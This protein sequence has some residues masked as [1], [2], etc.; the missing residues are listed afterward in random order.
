VAS[1]TGAIPDVVIHGE[2]GFLAEPQDVGSFVQH[3][4]SLLSDK[5]MAAELG[6]RACQ[7]VMRGFDWEVV[8]GKYERLCEDVLEGR[9][10][11]K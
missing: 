6:R 10:K 8:A 5:H 2:T 4:E 11:G 3:I 9:Q 1:N 7:H